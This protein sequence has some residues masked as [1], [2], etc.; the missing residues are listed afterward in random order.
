VPAQR[1]AA[2]APR[3]LARWR[4]CCGASL[5]VAPSVVGL[6]LGPV[7]EQ[8]LRRALVINQGDLSLLHSPVAVIL[9]HR[10]S[11]RFQQYQYLRIQR[12][13]DGRSLRPAS[14]LTEPVL[15]SVARPK[16]L[17]VFEGCNRRAVELQTGKEAKSVLRFAYLSAAVDYSL[18]GQ[19]L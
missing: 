8:Q 2:K 12:R 7:A 5:P 6:I 13:L 14:S 16:I 1:K 11:R 19:Q 18:F 10:C 4:R 15:R 17:V 3:R 9:Y